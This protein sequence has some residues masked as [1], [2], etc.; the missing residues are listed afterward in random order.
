MAEF[1]DLLRGLIGLDVASIGRSAIERAVR[2]RQ[3]ACGI[4]RAEYLD[5]VRQSSTER[6][7]LIDEVVVPE[8]W[9]FRD[10]QA[11]E[12]LARI[13]REEW[14]PSHP[15]GTLRLLSLPSSTGEEPYSIAMALLDAGIPSSRFR[16]DAIDVSTGALERAMRGVYGRNSFRGTSLGFRTRYFIDEPDGHR[17]KDEVRQQVQFRRGNICAADSISGTGVYDVIFCRNLLIYFDRATQ[18]RALDVLDRLLSPSGMLFLAPSET[19]LMLER[20]PSWMREAKAFAFRR[21]PATTANGKVA[22]SARPPARA[23]ESPR[24]LAPSSPPSG[25]SARFGATGP[26]T[27]APSRSTHRTVAP[28]HPRTLAPVV[29]AT[30]SSASS[31]EQATTLADQGRFVEAA[32]KCEEHVHA[33]GPSAAVYQL[34]GML[35]DATGKAGEAVA[36]YRKSLYL[37]PHNQ[38]VLIHLALLLEKLDQKAEATVLRGRERRVSGRLGGAAK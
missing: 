31:L 36:C 29:A 21:S 10:P 15:A 9:F 20:S 8:T 5:Y 30:P 19:S 27:L 7:A 22:S 1:V 11:F 38:E 13:A 18:H 16:I 23:S 25:A 26:R 37:E 12:T 2:D 34:L 32:A 28:S 4:A 35:R 24:T 6:Q 17:L 14:L 3:R 33:H